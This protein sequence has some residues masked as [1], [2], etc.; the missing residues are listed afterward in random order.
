MEVGAYHPKWHLLYSFPLEP[1]CGQRILEFLIKESIGL[2]KIVLDPHQ[3]LI[4]LVMFWQAKLL[5]LE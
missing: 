2:W 4:L 5:E 1:E 3:L